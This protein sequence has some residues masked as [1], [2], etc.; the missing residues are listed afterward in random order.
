[1]GQK[2][3]VRGAKKRTTLFLVFLGGSKKTKKLGK[4]IALPQPQITEPH[5]WKAG[6]ALNFRRLFNISG[7]HAAATRQGIL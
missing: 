4:K 3:G 7:L 6:K 5:A 2:L 1:L